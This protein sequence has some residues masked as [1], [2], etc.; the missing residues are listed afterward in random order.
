[1]REAH[2]PD[3]GGPGLVPR[4][5]DHSLARLVS[6]RDLFHVLRGDVPGANAG[7]GGAGVRDEPG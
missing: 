5:L 6:I 7:L 1:M 3:R 4:I 2:P